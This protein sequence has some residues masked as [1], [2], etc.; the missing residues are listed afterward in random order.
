MPIS[1]IQI[2]GDYVLDAESRR[3][4][5]RVNAIYDTVQ[6]RPAPG[7]DGCSNDERDRGWALQGASLLHGG[8][9]YCS[10]TA[11]STT[12]WPAPAS[13]EARRG[14]RPTTMARRPLS[15]STTVIDARVVAND[16]RRRQ[17]SSA[18]RRQR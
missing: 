4:R 9:F 7:R 2:G 16:A 17:I 3:R 11:P 5:R 10:A 12:E 15:S 8:M 13:I 6:V 1:R 18:K 14:R